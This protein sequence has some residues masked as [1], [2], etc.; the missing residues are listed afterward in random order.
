MTEVARVKMRGGL[1]TI[2]ANPGVV[3][4]QIGPYTHYLP[5]QVAMELAEAL[6]MA[7]LES[8]GGSNV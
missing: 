7:A 6:N 8:S 1:A 4:V 3:T 5:P 2:Y